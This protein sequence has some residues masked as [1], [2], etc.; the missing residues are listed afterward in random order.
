MEDVLPDGKIID[1]WNPLSAK[2][3][4]TF[5]LF[6]RGML[7]ACFGG[8]MVEPRCE[9]CGKSATPSLLGSMFCADCQERYEDYHCLHCGQRVVILREIEHSDVCSSCFLRARIDGLEERQ[10]AALR[11][12]V[13]SGQRFEAIK[14]AKQMLGV[15]IG[16]AAFVTDEL[17]KQS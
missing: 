9:V 16:D 3:A 13:K 8:G 11:Q 12:L 17:T 7:V 4:R 1:S 10:R 6:G 5:L 14:M 15:S 2:G